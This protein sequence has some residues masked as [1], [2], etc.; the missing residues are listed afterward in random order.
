MRGSNKLIVEA[1]LMASPRER[2]HTWLRERAD[3]Y[4]GYLDP[5]ADSDTEQALLSRQE[6][7]IDLG[8]AQF[9]TSEET[10]TALLARTLRPD[11]TKHDLAVRLGILSNKVIPTSML[12]GFPASL[13]GGQEAFVAWL[14]GAERID[15]WA[16][17]ENPALPDSFL[18]GFFEGDANWE[19]MGEELRLSAV[20]AFARSERAAREYSDHD[21]DGYAEYLHDHVFTTAWQLAEKV[22]T[23][24]DWAVALARLFE[25]LRLSPY[26]FDDPLSVAQ[27][28]YPDASSQQALKEETGSND[29]GYLG[30]YQRVRFGLARLVVR[31]NQARA[32]SLLTSKDIAFRCA[33]Y[34]EKHLTLEELQS[35]YQRDGKISLDPLMRNETLWKH[36]Q[37]R[38]ALQEM[39]WEAAADPTEDHLPAILRRIREEIIKRHPQWFAED[40]DRDV[41]DAPPE[42]LY[43]KQVLH[44]LAQMRDSLADCRRWI[45]WTF[46]LVVVIL[47]TLAWHRG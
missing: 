1:E 39:I 45:S 29:S 46:W 23:V 24:T 44:A 14:H 36:K 12:L 6:P 47:M 20:H 16:L 33:A 13:F 26:S 34:R 11:A 37:N 38:E 30:W 40:D 18:S 28:W 5:D 21:S 42:Q 3:K 32:T 8:L 22:P 7:L 15:I 43:Q 25:R 17:F 2:V 35:A 27:R 19:A 31:T 10:A 4:D 9:C 41:P